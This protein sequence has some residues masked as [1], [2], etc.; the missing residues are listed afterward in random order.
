VVEVKEEAAA[1]LAKVPEYA[2]QVAV[3]GLTT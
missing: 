1:E 3:H 2:A